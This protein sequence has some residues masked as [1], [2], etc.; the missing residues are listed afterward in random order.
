[1]LLLCKAAGHATRT[2]HGG[3]A[4]PGRIWRDLFIKVKHL[5]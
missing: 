5:L 1:M 3:L 2:Q 4:I